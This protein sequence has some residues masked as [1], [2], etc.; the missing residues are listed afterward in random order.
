[1]A[2][3]LTGGMGGGRLTELTVW[4]VVMQQVHGG[5]TTLKPGLLAKCKN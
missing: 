3:P 1:M 2:A 5:E 4:R